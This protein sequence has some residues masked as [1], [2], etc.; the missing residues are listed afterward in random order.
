MGNGKSKRQI[1]KEEKKDAKDM[2]KKAEKELIAADLA[3]EQAKKT[4]GTTTNNPDT[5][6]L[7][8]DG[9]GNY[10]VKKIVIVETSAASAAGKINDIEKAAQQKI[11]QKHIS[12]GSSEADAIA[13]SIETADKAAQGKAN[14]ARIAAEKAAEKSLA[15]ADVAT[16]AKADVAKNSKAAAV[17]AEEIEK[18]AAAAA[19]AQKAA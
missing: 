16:K 4:V 2:I 3:V 6:K 11:I 5:G 9:V 14:F 15:A 19:K 17:K 18:A 12:R 10:N 7:S 8:N 1:K 13:K